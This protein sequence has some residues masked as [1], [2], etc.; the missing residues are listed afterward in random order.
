MSPRNVNYAA[1]E[2]KTLVSDKD[3]AYDKVKEAINSEINHTWNT[4]E[5]F[6]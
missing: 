4:I 3:L 6:S 5:V 2:D 1:K